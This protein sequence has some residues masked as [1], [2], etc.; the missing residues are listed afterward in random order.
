MRNFLKRK[1]TNGFLILADGAGLVLSASGASLVAITGKLMLAVVLG[2]V[3]LGFFLRLASRRKAK[4]IAPMRPAN[5]VYGVSVALALVEVAV[6]VEATKLPIRFDQP[7]F[8]PWHWALVVFALFVAYRLNL[9]VF[10]SVATKRQ[11]AVAR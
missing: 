6:L 5:W 11:E 8:E 3:A 4:V 10:R 7:S 9:L 2:A 1:A